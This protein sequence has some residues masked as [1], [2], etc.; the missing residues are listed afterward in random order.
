MKHACAVAACCRSK[1]QTAS[2]KGGPPAWQSSFK[3]EVFGGSNPFQETLRFWMVSQW[4]GRSK[5]GP[6]NFRSTNTQ[7]G[8]SLQGCAFLESRSAKIHSKNRAEGWSLLR[9]L[10]AGTRIW[11]PR[12]GPSLNSTDVR[13][14]GKGAWFCKKQP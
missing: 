8:V 7:C 5:D 14:L 9:D 4:A 11:D 10:L 12:G 3:R 13:P 6:L 2:T 1:S